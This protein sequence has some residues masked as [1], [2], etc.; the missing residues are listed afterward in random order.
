MPKTTQQRL[1]DY[2]AALDLRLD[3]A[4]AG[5]QGREITIGGRTVTYSELESEIEFYEKRI[6]KLTRSINGGR[7]RNIIRQGDV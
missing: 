6:A 4:A 3:L 7:G 2:E 5:R 1:A